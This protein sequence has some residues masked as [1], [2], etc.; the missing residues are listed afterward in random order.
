[1]VICF[2]CSNETKLLLDHLMVKAG[3][4]DYG[5][6]ISTAISNLSV[7]HDEMSGH[8]LIILGEE[9][10]RIE[11]SRQSKDRNAEFHSIE[12]KE[13]ESVIS[14]DKLTL[15]GEQ[16]IPDIFCRINQKNPT[17]GIT[18]IPANEA[19]LRKPVPLNKWL[20]GQYNRLLPVKATCRALANLLKEYTSGVPVNVA[21]E[22]I[23]EQAAEL[24]VLLKKAD[25]K[26]GHTRDEEFSTAFP[27]PGEDG[28]KSRIRYANQF[29]ANINNEGNIFGLPAELKL[30]NMVNG[31]KSQLTIS[32]TRIGLELA[33][34]KSP[35]LDGDLM[36]SQNKFSNSEI[37]LLLSHIKENV[38]VENFTYHTILQGIL[39]GANTPE[40]LD[41]YLSDYLLSDGQIYT[42]SFLSSQR[43]GALSRMTDLQLLD[44]I[45]DGVKVSYKIT[46]SGMEFF[47]ESSL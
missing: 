14:S 5:E 25:K 16:A 47:S 34:L 8:D 20:F 11:K 13:T 26:R 19:H 42:K 30:I 31:D 46:D 1:M 18:E 7:I 3:Y 29:V 22:K 9:K 32:L 12:S 44:R 21:R 40:A 45:R 35:I 2:R 24:G 23:S 17:F 4:K 15:S 33:Q 27:V 10:D 43:S 36:S 38:W 41:T 37:K 28:R 39:D 6:I